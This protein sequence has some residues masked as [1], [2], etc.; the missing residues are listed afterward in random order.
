MNILI[1]YMPKTELQMQSYDAMNMAKNIRV[2]GRKVNRGG[3]LDLDRIRLAQKTRFARLGARARRSRRGG[4]GRPQ[5]TRGPV[6]V[7]DGRRSE[8]VASG[9]DGGAKTR[10]GAR[11]RR[12]AGVEEGEGGRRQ[13]R[14][15]L[16]GRMRAP[17]AG[18]GT[19]GSAPHGGVWWW[20]DVRSG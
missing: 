12:R 11:R 18:G 8:A 20:R 14:M 1:C 13:I 7:A 19:S 15:G 9:V 2:S 10:R 5:R 6:G 17:R 3:D 16:G 4:V